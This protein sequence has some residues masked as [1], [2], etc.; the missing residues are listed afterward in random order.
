MVEKHRNRK[1][2]SKAVGEREK[3]NREAAK[4]GGCAAKRL[5]SVATGNLGNSKVEKQRNREARRQGSREG[6]K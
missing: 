2:E 1:Q 6:G 3:A 4:Q 5:G